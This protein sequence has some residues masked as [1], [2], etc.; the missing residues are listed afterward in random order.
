MGQSEFVLA[1]TTVPPVSIAS[2]HTRL[3][4]LRR[5]RSW[6][7][8]RANPFGVLGVVMLVVVFLAALVPGLLTQYDP[9]KLNLQDK[10]LSP[11]VTHWFGTDDVG[12]DVYTRVIFGARVTLSST[13][14]VLV[15][16]AGIGTIVGSLAGFYGGWIDTVMMRVTDMFLAFPALIL[17]LAINAALG[18]GL[19]QAML[20]VAISWWPSYARLVRGQVLSTKQE[21]YVTAARVMGSPVPALIGKHILLNSFPPILVR[22]T[23]D[24]GFIALTTAGLSFL[25][26][27]V[28]PPTPEW[29]RMVADGRSFL[30]DQW[31]WTTF[32]GLALFLLVVGSNLTGDVVREALDPSLVNR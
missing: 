12:R 2:P 30:L 28:E 17:A 5:S 32:P 14:M 23:L 25:G 31:W 26:L 22:M 16:A 27:G 15:L 1:A 11:S 8:L 10:F 6:R 18:R 13:L 3:Q 29:G 4:T 7:A 24:I 9:V 20:A 19:T 21:E